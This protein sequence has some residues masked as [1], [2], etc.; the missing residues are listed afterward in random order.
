MSTLETIIYSII[1]LVI[2]YYL[3]NKLFIK[4]HRKAKIKQAKQDQEEATEKD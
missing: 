2:V 1:G 3:I 4:P